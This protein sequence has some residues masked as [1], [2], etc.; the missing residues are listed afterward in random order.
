MIREKVRKHL[1]IG[2]FIC[3]L[4]VLLSAFGT[5]G[6]DGKITPQ[7]LN[8]YQTGLRYLIIHGMGIIAIGTLFI[9]LNRYQVWIF[10]MLYS[11]MIM[12][13]LSLILHATRNLLGVPFHFFA[14][15]A[16]IGGLCYAGAWFLLAV[17][18][19]KK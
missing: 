14:L 8:T 10:I 9:F 17:Y 13:S 6:L 15:I 12:F 3:G 19:S 11:G 18:L 1:V 4:Y 7:Q 2:S 16:P 5:H